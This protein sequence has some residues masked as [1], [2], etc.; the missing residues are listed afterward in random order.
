V[1]SGPR[2]V[3][4]GIDAVGAALTLLVVLLDVVAERLRSAQLARPGTRGLLVL[5]AAYSLDAVRLRGLEHAMLSRDLGG[6]FDVVWHVH[7]LVGADL[8]EPSSETA[9]RP[10]EVKLAPG[11]LYVE[12]YPALSAQPRFPLTSFVLAQYLLLRRL[13][14]LLRSGEVQIVRAGDPYYLGLL[15]LLLA[16]AHRV[17]LVLRINGNYDQIYEAVGRLA[18]P[19]LFKRRWVEKRIDRFVLRRADLVAGANRDNLGFALRNGTPVERGVVF[20]YGALID[21]VHRTEPDDRRD[22]R[23]ELGLEGRRLLIAVTRLEPVKHTADVL[24]TLAAVRAHHPDVAAVV[25]GDGSELPELQRLAS[26]LDLTGHVAFAGSRDQSWI[27][28]ALASS[29]VY[30]APSAGRALVEAA[31]AELPLVAYDVDWHSEL[32]LE[33]TSGLLVP[34]RDVTKM[35]AAATRLLDDPVLA[36]R[37]GRGARTLAGETMDPEALMDLERRSL[38]QLLTDRAVRR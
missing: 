14:A 6:W 18:Y 7:P 15:G 26:E 32:V 12:G 36:T 22:V 23:S 27:A 25:I 31:L 24:R 21:P 17:P 30:V 13:H 8:R 5:D 34:F 16:R 28:R 20:P 37:L 19:R 3:R 2:V 4:A 9:G 35:A 29:T 33:G 38:E 10:R 1:V 11:H